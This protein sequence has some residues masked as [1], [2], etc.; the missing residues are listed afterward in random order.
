MK[1]DGKTTERPEAQRAIRCVA[2]VD[3]CFIRPYIRHL[4]VPDIQSN[5]S[6]KRNRFYKTTYHDMLQGKSP[7]NTN[8]G[9]KI[10][11]SEDNLDRSTLLRLVKCE[12]NR[13]QSLHTKIMK[14]QATL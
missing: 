7:S 10:H 3:Y 13:E 4:L 8:W 6:L 12:S 1:T 11:V 5:V 14:L 2:V 9:L